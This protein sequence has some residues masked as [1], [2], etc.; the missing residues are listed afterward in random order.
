MRSKTEER[1]KHKRYKIENSVSISSQGIFQVTDISKG[2]F[3][4]KCPAYTPI[5]D[6]WATDILSSAASLQDFPANRVWVSMTENGT[7]E[8]LPTIVGVK[9]GKLNNKQESLLLDLLDNLENNSS[10]SH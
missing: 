4:F 8:Y 2:G 5:L 3:C 7:H 10:A 9:F 1:R 6:I